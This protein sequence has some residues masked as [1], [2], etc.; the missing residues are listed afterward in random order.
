MSTKAVETIMASQ[1][2]GMPNQ[3]ED[4]Q[5]ENTGT[6]TAASLIFPVISSFNNNQGM[7]Q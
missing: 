1:L 6:Y 5:R 7:Q 3:V 2:K 4:Y